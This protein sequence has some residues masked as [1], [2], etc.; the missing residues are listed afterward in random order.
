MSEPRRRAEY[1]L[2]FKMEAVRLVK[3]GQAIFVTAKVLGILKATLDNWSSSAP[4]DNL[5]ERE[6]SP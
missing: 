2:E 6:I 3:G 5:G 1:T 4:R